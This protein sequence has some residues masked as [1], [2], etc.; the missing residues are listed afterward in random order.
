M[1]AAG[2]GNGVEGWLGRVLLRALDKGLWG[3]VEDCG[4]VV[5]VCAAHCPK[6]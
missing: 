3:V 6:R 4:G 2:G 1:P 5:G